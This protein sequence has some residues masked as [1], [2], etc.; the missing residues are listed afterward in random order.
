[1]FKVI[2]VVY[3]NI[4]FSA[5]LNTQ[6]TIGDLLLNFPNQFNFYSCDCLKTEISKYDGKL[7]K[8]AKL[9]EE[10]LELA[11][12]LIFKNIEFIDE[13]EILIKFRLNAFQLVKDIDVNDLPFIALNKYLESTLWTGDKKLINGLKQK[14]YKTLATTEDLVLLRSM[15]ESQ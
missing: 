9:Y 5:I 7:L 4:V 2:V 8:I 15:L 14:E 3:S 12:Q 1:M 11:K 6:S 13:Q 10:N